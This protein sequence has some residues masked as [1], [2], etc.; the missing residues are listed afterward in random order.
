ML[1]LSFANNDKEMAGGGLNL[2]FRQD[3]ILAWLREDD[4][5]ALA[6]LFAAAD[7]VRAANVGDE[8]HLRALVE[9]SN[10]CAR[11]CGYC[12]LRAGNKALQR[13][14]M[15]ADEIFTCVRQATALGYGTTVLQAGEDFGLTGRWIADLVR[16]I[17]SETPLA[18]TLSL[19]EREAE[20]YAL[21]RDAGADRY[22]LRFE[23]S[24][25]AL[26]DFIHPP[27]PLHPDRP[28][29]RVAILKE[30]RVMGYEIGSGIMIGI[31]GQSLASIAEDILL[32]R[33]LDLDMIG[34]GPYIPHPGTPLG[35]VPISARTVPEARSAKMGLSPFAPLDEKHGGAALPADQQAARH[36]QMVCKVIALARLACPQANIPST[37]ALATINPTSGREMGLQSGANVVM[38][39]LTPVEY[40]AMY[41]IYP[42]KACINETGEECS[43]CLAGRILGLGRRIGVGPGGRRRS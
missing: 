29:D 20:D 19:G 4:P 43:R 32:F 39:N 38:P 25:R 3:E 15:S 31:P 10:H 41:E 23:T 37:T 1:N 40:R 11:Q 2:R 12:G 42:N 22:L 17:K 35:I 5:K 27:S 34:V 14:R 8:V 21:W 26:F 28:S 13:Y 24:D 36:E 33:E 16:R 9:I 18:V 6:R 7:A 30:L